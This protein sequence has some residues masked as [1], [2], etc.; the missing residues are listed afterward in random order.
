MK[1]YTFSLNEYFNKTQKCY[2]FIDGLF[3]YTKTIKKEV[4]QTVDVY[5]NSYRT[6]RLKDNVKN[7]NRELLLKYFN[8]NMIDNS[9]QHKYEVCISKI[10][11]CLCF[12]YL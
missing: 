5:G 7:N 1:T 12:L 8:Y 11:Y 10:Y 3:N 9:F 2:Y 4:F 6:D